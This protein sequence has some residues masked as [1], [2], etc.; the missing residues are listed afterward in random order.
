MLTPVVLAMLVTAVAASLRVADNSR[1]DGGIKAGY[2]RCY[3]RACQPIISLS[4]GNRL[5]GLQCV[6]N[7]ARKL[8]VVVLEPP[9]AR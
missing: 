9:S 3:R 1:T 8:I 2:V 6:L 4:R 5:I 7:K